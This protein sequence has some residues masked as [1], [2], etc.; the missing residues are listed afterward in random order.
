MDKKEFAFLTELEYSDM[1][2][3]VKEKFLHFFCRGKTQQVVGLFA[4]SHKI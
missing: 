4:K 1:N 2:F 3:T